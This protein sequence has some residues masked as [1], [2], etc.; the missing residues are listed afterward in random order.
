MTDLSA[1]TTDVYASSEDTLRYPLDVEHLGIRI[2]VPLLAFVTLILG[3][4]LIPVLLDLLGLRSTLVGFLQ[5]PLIIGAGVGGAFLADRL[6]KG[7][8]RSGRELRLDNRQLVM[9]EKDGTE[10]TILWGER[11]NV[12][13]WRFTVARRGRVPKGYVCLALQFIQDEEQITFYGFI[14]P[15]RVDLL[16]N[17]DAFTPLAAR[18]TLKDERLSMRIAGQ[19]RRLLQ[20]ED[21]RWQRGGELTADAFS[22]LW[23]RL[24]DRQIA[25]QG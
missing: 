6:L 17:V 16:P 23:A 24:Q 7:R 5:L 20:A 10:K 22:D 19:Q 11:V 4:W 25:F 8:W 2:A 14:S 13:A 9:R 15:K 3:W 18:A 1:A 21:E 12:L